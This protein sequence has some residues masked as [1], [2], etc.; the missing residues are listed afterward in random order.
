MNWKNP[1]K[2]ASQGTASQH[3][4]ELVQETPEEVIRLREKQQLVSM[5]EDEDFNN[6]M[7]TPTALSKTPKAP[8]STNKA[9]AS[10]DKIFNKVSL[11]APPPGSTPNS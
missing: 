3:T 10:F 7:N 5:F 11:Q 2:V 4:Q 9:K 1:G 8:K 6:Q